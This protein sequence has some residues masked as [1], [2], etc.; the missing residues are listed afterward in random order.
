MYRFPRKILLALPAALVLAVG[1]AAPASAAPGP[2]A[3]CSAAN[4]L[5]TVGEAVSFYYDHG[6]TE[7]EETLVPF[8]AGIDTPGVDPAVDDKT[9]GNGDGYVCIRESK[10]PNTTIN[11][12]DNKVTIT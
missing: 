6:G 3:R 10:A 12:G 2:V 9:K 11:I 4:E 5:L 7:A 1:V 8:V